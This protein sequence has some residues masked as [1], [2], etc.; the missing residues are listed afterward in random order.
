MIHSHDSIIVRTLGRIVIPVA[1]L[2]GFYVL[3]FGQ[4][5][6]GGGFVGGVVLAASMILANLIFGRDAEDSR[7]ART[8]L[9]SILGVIIAERRSDADRRSEVELLVDL[10]LRG[11]R[12]D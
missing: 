12:A 3:I 4:Y 5:G 9:T 10:L 1:Q 2:F 8:V 7:L 11:M 6:P